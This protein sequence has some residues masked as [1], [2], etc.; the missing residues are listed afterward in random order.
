MAKQ[1]QDSQETKAESQVLPHISLPQT[2]S[3]KQLAD[4]LQVS[5]VEIIKQ[6]M[7][8][9]VMANI[10][11]AVDFDTATLVADH[12]GY[13]AKKQPVFAQI[14]RPISTGGGKLSPRPPVIT[15]I[16]HVDHGKT[17]LLDAIRQ[18]NVIAT[19]AGAITQ[20]IGA[21]QVE[22]DSRKITFLDTPGHQAFTAMRARGTQL[23]DIAVLVVAADD[24]VM[25][26]TIEAINHARAANVP[27]VVAIN[28]IDKANANPDKLKQQLADLDLLIEEW[29]GDTVCVSISA[30]KKQGIDELLEN[31]LL[32]ADILE[33][34]G[35]HDCPAEGV[36]IEARLDKTRG[37]V[38][39]LLVQKGTLKLGDII[40][41]SNTWGRVKAM[42]NELGKHLKKAEPATPVEVLGLNAVPHAG[43][44]FSVVSSEREAKMLF[45][46]SEDTQRKAPARAKAV[47]LS[48]LSTQ[49]SDGQIKELNIILKTDVQGSIEPIRDSLEQ[50]GD[51][52]VKV[53]VIHSG[54]G[55]IT[56]SD[57][58]LAL[59]SKGI[60][61]GF[62]S[63]PE[64][65]AQRLAE[66]EGISI[67]YYNVIYELVK[68][69]DKALKGMLEPTYTEVIEGQAEILAVFGTSKKGKVAGVSV[70]EGKLRR[71]ALARV[72]RKGESIHESRINSL[73]RFKEDVKE[74]ATGFE[75]G[76][77]IEGFT[78]FQVGDIIQSYRQEIVS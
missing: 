76:I 60:I 11:Q 52:R 78:D 33:L 74:I 63:R 71:D 28:K 64:P 8:N 65:G 23:T 61:I 27:I 50:L 13:K 77:K 3:V 41:I 55:G 43:D 31:L 16:G 44:S 14:K 62:N 18:S 54:S 73:R 36:V 4:L 22:V 75:C 5:A 70:K 20:H 53:R 38:A 9:G 69:V 46:K 48:N 30:K 15:I 67:R 7:R 34:K 40:A 49:I 10:N 42:F 26:Q 39:T 24:G 51:E 32:V 25:P 6:L 47:S 56:E 58:L 12:F 45:E 35:E 72:I 17:S 19:E 29:G 57:V 37:P 1:E 21:Y 59:A 2:L 68:D 66:T